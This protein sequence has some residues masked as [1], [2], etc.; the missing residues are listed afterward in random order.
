MCPPIPTPKQG[1]HDDLHSTPQ[2]PNI[3]VVTLRAWA[4]SWGSSPDSIV[5]KIACSGGS[6]SKVFHYNTRYRQSWRTPPVLVTV[7]EVEPNLQKA[8]SDGPIKQV[9]SKTITSACEWACDLV[10]C[11]LPAVEVCFGHVQARSLQPSH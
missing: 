6:G 7:M 11:V 4:N 5:V 1:P 8:T 3:G 2:N 9:R 10:Y